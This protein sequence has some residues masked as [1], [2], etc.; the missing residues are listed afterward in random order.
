VWG[1]TYPVLTL[2]REAANSG[3]AGQAALHT[4]LSARR[5]DSPGNP[6]A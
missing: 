2:G 4:P 1:A 6:L 3:F 5:F